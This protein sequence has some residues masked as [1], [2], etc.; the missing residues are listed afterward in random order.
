[1]PVSVRGRFSSPDRFAWSPGGRAGMRGMDAEPQSGC[2]SEGGRPVGRRLAGAVTWGVALGAVATPLVLVVIVGVLVWAARPTGAPVPRGAVAT[3]AGMG[4]FAGTF[5]T[6]GIALAVAV[7]VGMGAALC[8]S[9]Q[10]GGRLGGILGFG[11]DALAGIPGVVFGLWGYRALIPWFGSAR[12]GGDLLV[13][14]LVLA[15]M[16][17][18]TCASA[19]GRALAGVPVAVREQGRVLGLSEWQTVRG[20]VVPLAWRGMVAGMLLALGR[21]VGETVAV[22][23]VSGAGAGVSGWRQPVTTAAALLLADLRLAAADPAGPAAH[24]LA[25]LALLLLTMTCVIR[26]AAATLQQAATPGRGGVEGG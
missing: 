22:L 25:W 18:P 10:K 7:P 1:M 5:A 12:G 8:L 24:T 13:A 15:A 21:A 11:V 17:A 2:R 3:L 23:M 4:A 20:L 16:V 6:A 14:S 26:L 19:C 9:E